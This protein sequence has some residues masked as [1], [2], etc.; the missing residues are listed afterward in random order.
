MNPKSFSGIRV[1][2]W[3]LKHPTQKIHF[4]E[5]CR[6]L[7]LGPPTVKAY[8]E[9]LIKLNWLQDERNANL[10]I[11]FLNNEHYVVKALKRAYFLNLLSE[12][13]VGSLVENTVISLA[14][15]GSHASGEYDEKSDVDLLIIGRKEEVRHEYS[16][17]LENKL[18]KK[19]QIT[20]LPLDKWENNK[21]NDPFMLSVLKNHVI[22]K[23]APL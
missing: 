3:F 22:L 6:E 1:L 10:R 5:L 14:V 17:I 18:G 19:F 11:F 7:K 9:E 20:V 15:Y 8:C 16:R 2:G 12:G 4:K 13:K 23:G 21:Q